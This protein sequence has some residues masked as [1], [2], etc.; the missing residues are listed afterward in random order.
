MKATKITLHRPIGIISAPPARAK[1]RRVS[2]CSFPAELVVGGVPLDELGVSVFSELSLVLAELL[3][4]GVEFGVGLLSLFCPKL[5]PMKRTRTKD[6]DPDMYAS[7]RQ[8]NRL[9]G[10]FVEV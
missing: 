3:G 7:E 2:G 9:L 1:S 6:S 4:V 10:V 8:G 5:V